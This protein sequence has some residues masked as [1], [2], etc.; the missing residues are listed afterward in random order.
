MVSEMMHPCI[1][2]S[3]ICMLTR[4]HLCMMHVYKLTY[5]MHMLAYMD[6]IH[7]H[8]YD[9]YIQSH[10]HDCISKHKGSHTH[11]CILYSYMVTCISG[12]YSSWC[13]LTWSWWWCTCMHTWPHIWCMWQ[14]IFMHTRSHTQWLCTHG[15]ITMRLHAYMVTHT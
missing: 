6:H 12:S 15:L 5:L 1:Y 2:G 11:P 3:R 9:A 13:M 7:D 14:C 4:W 8:V 10:L